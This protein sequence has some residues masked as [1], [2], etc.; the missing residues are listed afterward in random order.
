MRCSSLRVATQLLRL[1]QLPPRE[2]QGEE[3]SAQALL[4]SRDGSAA[5]VR[6]E[7]A[8]AS[9]ARWRRRFCATESWT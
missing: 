5:V 3:G 4:L 1:K 6:G 9:R 7:G 8:A 2:G